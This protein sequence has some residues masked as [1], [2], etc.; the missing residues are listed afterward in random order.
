MRFLLIIFRQYPGQT[1]MMLAALVFAGVAEGIGL[2]AMLPL[3]AITLGGSK[4]ATG[5][6]ATQAEQMIQKIFDW[7]GITPT[8]EFLIIMIFTAM[9]LKTVLVLFANK[10]VGY[11]V[12]QLTTDLRH[13]A[14]RAFISASWEFHLSQPIG[15]LAAAMGGE[16]AKTAKAY[17]IGVSMIVLLIHALIYIGV[18]LMVS[19]KAT[20]IAL[21]AGMFFWY[22]LSRLVTKAKKAGH[23]QV[24]LRRSLSSFFMDTILSIKSLKATA[25][26]DRAEA[27]LISKTNKIKKVLKKL[28]MSKE[29]LSAYQE[30]MLVTFL[31]VAIY[32]AIAVW[33][34]S[35]ITLLVLIVLLRR[36]LSKLGKVQK[37]YQLM[38]IQEAGYWTM[39]ETLS[40]A[41]KMREKHLGDKKPTLEQ[42]I[43][44]EGVTFAYSKDK[45]FNNISL[46]FPAGKITAIIGPSGS[47][48]TTVLDLVIG[49][50]RS[51][52][53]EVWIDDLPLEQVN[54]HRW[55]R[56]I[57]YVPQDTLLLHDSV[58][59]NTT[60]GD[61]DITEKE[62]E[63]ALK[64]AEI[65]DFIEAMPKGL[66]SSVGARGLRL[67]G[68][69]RQRIAI[70]RALT[71]KPKLLVLDEATTALDPKTEAAICE[72]LRKLR[73]ELT[74][75]AISHQPAIL[76]IADRAYRLKDGKAVLISDDTKPGEAEKDVSSAF[77]SIA[78]K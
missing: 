31:L 56:M 3:L 51:Q 4:T 38:G 54:L 10:R 24:K 22:P 66:Y 25:R 68:G 55:R 35:P 77:I 67:S 50:L 60:L 63:E 57:G 32:M 53:G 62:V 78:A 47:G 7:L 5:G 64:K 28:V 12:A 59:I 70:A 72:T 2:S 65:W 8:L 76:N 14:L 37:Q 39:T 61:P 49:L 52:K 15:R 30:A 34:M 21:A 27:I 29:S 13:H 1:L 9:M 71:M 40:T 42:S 17:A 45:V 19:W 11:T 6:K 58:L 74:I 44:L 69:Q 75:L 16:T 43:R 18:A 41:R 36:I 46:V 33:G 26:E 23:R 20:L 48:K 73:G